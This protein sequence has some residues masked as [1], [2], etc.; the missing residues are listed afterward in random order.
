M[1]KALPRILKPKCR[2]CGKHRHPHEF[3]G[4]T[5][6]GYCIECLEWHTHALDVFAGHE[7]PRGCQECGRS[8]ERL[9]QETGSVDVQFAM[10]RKDGIYQVLCMSCD[11][12]YMSQQR[13]M[14]QNTPA[15]A[16]AA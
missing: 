11:A 14:F 2:F 5:T 16:K 10:H 1:L 8:S 15:G 3:V 6:V 9:A 4:G 13:A 7:I 12:K